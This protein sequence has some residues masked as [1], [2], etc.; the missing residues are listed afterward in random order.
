[1]N[2][3]ISVIVPVYKAENY[4]NRCIDSLLSQTFYAFEVLL[5]NDGSPD[6]S[7]EI[8]DE[9][10]QRDSRVRVFNKRNGGVSSAR[11][12]G[13]DHA[14]GEYVIHV[15]PDD[16]V[17][18]SMLEELYNKAKEED[19]DMVIC[20]Y[21]MNYE[22]KQVYKKQ[23]PSSLDHRTVLKELFQQLHG[24]CCNKLVR[25]VCYNDT[26]TRFPEGFVLWEDRFVCCSLCLAELKITYLNKAFYH[27]DRISNANSLARIPSQQGLESC[28]RFIDYFESRLI[29]PKYEEVFFDL[30]A[31]VKESAFLL[32]VP[33]GNFRDLYKEINSKYIYHGRNT[34]LSLCTRFALIGNDEVLRLLSNTYVF[35]KRLFCKYYHK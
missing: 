34:I 8:C 12:C 29:G 9:Y 33:Y 26:G 13:M 21:Y 22:N 11:Q 27:Y 6:R 5:V 1:M 24:S 4:I 17:E 14:K 3:A 18:S 31:Y 7:G 30:K 15:D 10:A 25:R 32:K 20:D 23:E 19:A 2:V 35:M 16:W 28:V